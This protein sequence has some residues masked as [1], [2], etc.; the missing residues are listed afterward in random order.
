MNAVRNRSVML[1]RATMLNTMSKLLN[2]GMTIEQIVERSTANPA[3]AIH[4]PELG[5]LSE[6]AIADIAIFEERTGKFGFLDS[7]HAR[8]AGDKKLACVMTVVGGRSSIGSSNF[9]KA[10]SRTSATR[11][12]SPVRFGSSR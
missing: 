9:G 3:H 6:G 4:H 1:P 5:T 7:G 2:L 11:D 10:M 12:S 8:L